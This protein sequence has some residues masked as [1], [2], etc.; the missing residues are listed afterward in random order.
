MDCGGKRSA[1]PLWM[2]YRPASEESK[3]VSVLRSA[4]A[5]QR[6]SVFLELAGDQ[7]GNRIERGV[8]IRAVGTHGNDGAVAGGEHH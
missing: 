1:T 8:G 5:V 3:A 2:F 6:D 4:T 7:I